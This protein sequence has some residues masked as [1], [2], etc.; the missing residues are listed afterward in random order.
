VEAHLSYADLLIIEGRFNEAIEQSEQ[1]KK[2][3]PLNPICKGVPGLYLLF[4]HRYNDAITAFQEVLKIDPGHVL[5]LSN[6]PVALHQVGRYKEELEAWKSYYKITYNKIEHVF[7]FGFAR[8]GYTGALNLE[9]DSLS[10][11]SKTRH[12]ILPFDIACLYA[13]AG[14]KERTMDMLE[15]CYEVHDLNS[16][17]IINYPVFESLHNDPRFQEL[18]HKMNLPYKPIE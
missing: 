9:A 5:A 14:N 15:R 1:A 10:S 13:C 17:F 7:D 12:Y 6:L 11:Q 2:L 16:P 8:G 4:A 3:D 18:A